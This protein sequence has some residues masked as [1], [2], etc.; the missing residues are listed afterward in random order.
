MKDTL[1]NTSKISNALFQ[2]IHGN[3]LIYNTCWED[4]HCDRQLLNI[5][6]DSRL[7][8]ITST[9]CNAL[10]YALDCP[11]EIHCVDMNSRQNALLELKKAAFSYGSHD[12]LYQLFGNGVHKDVYAFYKDGLLPF[13]PDF[14]QAY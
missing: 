1:I 7:V 2:N 11:S 10:D 9:G 14:A 5:Q 13:L 8:M 6:P 12:D 3:N 4:P